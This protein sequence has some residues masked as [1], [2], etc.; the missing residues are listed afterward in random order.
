MRS[1]RT[2][3]VAV[4]TVALTAI[5][6]FA[7]AYWTGTGSGSGS[8]TAGTGSTAAL[9]GTIAPGSAPGTS[10]AV[11][12]T[13]ANAAD[14]PMQVGTVHLDGMTV[15]AGHAACETADFTMADVAEDHLVPADATA[16]ALPVDGALVYANTAVDQDACK[17]ATLT[18]ALSS[19]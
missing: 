17:G 16:E 2:L 18:L 12:F 6:G 9:I 4:V 7:Y 11:S 8:G 5:A 15:D 19:N 3:K 13:A 14:S 1:K 10:S